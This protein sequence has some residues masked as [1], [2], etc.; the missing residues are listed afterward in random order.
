[1]P[2]IFAQTRTTTDN[3]EI[4]LWSGILAVAVLV[5]FGV[6]A[7]FRRI[8]LRDEPQATPVFSLEDLRKMHR[9]GQ[10]SDEEFDRARAKMIAR[11]RGEPPTEANDPPQAEQNQGDDAEDDDK[12][13]GPKNE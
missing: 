8:M 9:Q 2:L 11:T 7:L 12:T 13:Q 6:V 3:S 4:L 1:M 5:L 10:L